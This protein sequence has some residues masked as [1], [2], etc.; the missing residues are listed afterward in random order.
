MKFT[1]V[2]A[3]T[4]LVLSMLFGET[5]A[6]REP[7]FKNSGLEPQLRKQLEFARLIRVEKR[8]RSSHLVLQ[9][10]AWDFVAEHLSSELPK[11]PRASKLLE[12]VLRRVKLLLQ[13]SERSLADFVGS[14][15]D[16]RK[17]AVVEG[18]GPRMLDDEVRLACLALA[19]GETRKRV[20][21]K[22][23][24]PKLTIPRDALDRTLLAM[25]T[26]GQLVLY[27]LD[28][29]AEITTE[30]EKAALL[31]AGQPRHIVYLEA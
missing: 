22:D 31:I 21:L 3:Q 1:P 8:G 24:R 19:H 10:E 30:D 18:D 11:T 2:P 27:K 9:D 20:R 17:N 4:F 15:T 23:L 6:E 12:R 26:S 16:A 5:Q 14:E 29:P 25:Q 13:T 28:N 7:T